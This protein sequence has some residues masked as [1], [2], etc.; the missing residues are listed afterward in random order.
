MEY[1]NRMSESTER[2]KVHLDE[3]LGTLPA[4]EGWVRKHRAP[5]GALRQVVES[6]FCESVERQQAASA[7]RRIKTRGSSLRGCVRLLSE[8]TERQTAHQDERLHFLLC[9]VCLPVRKQRA[10]KGALRLHHFH[11]RA[12]VERGIRKHRAPNGA[13]RRHDCVALTARAACQKA[14]SAKRCI[15]THLAGMRGQ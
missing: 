1:A 9:Y 5:K 10:P 7:K 13:L 8:S 6:C 2:Q 12:D 3:R 11:E 15:R 14:P 4:E